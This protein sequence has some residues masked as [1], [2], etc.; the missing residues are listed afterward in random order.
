MMSVLGIGGYSRDIKLK[1][2]FRIHAKK[3]QK[4]R[5]RQAI[6]VIFC[7]QLDVWQSEAGAKTWGVLPK[8]PESRQGN[9]YSR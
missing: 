3:P 1:Q 7:Y 9:G 5:Q 4:H 2:I 8:S 6:A